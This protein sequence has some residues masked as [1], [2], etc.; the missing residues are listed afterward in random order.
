[1]PFF[2]PKPPPF[3]P[4]TPAV[5]FPKPRRFFP[6]APA[7]PSVV[8]AGRVAFSGRVFPKEAAPLSRF[9]ASSWRSPGG[10]VALSRFAVEK[11]GRNGRPFALRRA[12][13]RGG[14]AL[15][16]FAV[17]KF[18]AGWRFAT[19]KSAAGW[20]FAVRKSFGGELLHRFAVEKSGQ[21]G[22]HFAL[23]R[24]EVPRKWS[25]FALRRAK[26]R[27]PRIPPRRS[28]GTAVQ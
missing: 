14:L 27:A 12:K 25:T 15:R 20:H 5:F 10:V 11:S 16:R 2:F 1:M 19:R 28:Q 13:V 26:G 9:A 8:R 7:R 23:R 6:K 4:G 3:L 21:N 18:A 22:R 17:R 24:E